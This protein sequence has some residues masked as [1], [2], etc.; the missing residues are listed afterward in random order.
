MGSP[1]NLSP[2]SSSPLKYFILKNLK[3]TAKLEELYSEYLYTY[4]LDF[5]H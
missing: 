5:Y 4:Y 2:M 1:F 3:H